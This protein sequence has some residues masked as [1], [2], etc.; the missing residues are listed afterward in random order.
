MDME[1]RYTHN[2]GTMADHRPLRIGRNIAQS[3]VVT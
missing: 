2:A 1:R 3:F